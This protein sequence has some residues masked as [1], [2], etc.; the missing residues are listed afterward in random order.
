M[1]HAEQQLEFAGRPPSFSRAS[2]RPAS[3]TSWLAAETAT[4]RPERRSTT[5]MKPSRRSRA[6]SAGSGHSPLTTRTPMPRHTARV[7]I[8]RASRPAPRYGHAERKVGR[9]GA[10][11]VEETD[12]GIRRLNPMGIAVQPH[13]VFHGN[14]RNVFG[15]RRAVTQGGRL[16]RKIAVRSAQ[17][18]APGPSP[19]RCP[20]LRRAGQSGMSQNPRPRS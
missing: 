18:R 3:G 13:P 8:V 20:G 4:P 16:D 10:D 2:A 7:G 12:A 5:A 1:R 11:L 6:G 14:G 17:P 19:H 15:E 9:Y